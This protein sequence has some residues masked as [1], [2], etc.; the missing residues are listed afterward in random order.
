ML[1]WDVWWLNCGLELLVFDKLYHSG[2]GVFLSGNWVWDG[3]RV[4]VEVVLQGVDGRAI[5][6]LHPNSL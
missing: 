4:L 5:W 2:G 3:V 1:R 6:R